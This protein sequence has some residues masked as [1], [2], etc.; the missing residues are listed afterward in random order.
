M[1]KLISPNRLRELDSEVRKLIGEY[2][3]IALR[4]T[5][6]IQSRGPKT[7]QKDNGK[8]GKKT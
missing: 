2:G 8:G 3:K 4:E 7:L 1:R 6:E 5:I